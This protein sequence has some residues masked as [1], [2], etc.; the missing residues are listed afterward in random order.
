MTF[1]INRHPGTVIFVDDD[2]NFLKTIRTVVDQD[3]SVRTFAMTSDFVDHIGAKIAVARD[4][5]TYQRRAMDRYRSG[6]SVATEVLRYWNSFPERFALPQ[7]VVIDY[8]MPNMTGLEALE[9]CE[10]WNGKR[11]LMTGLADEDLVCKAFN[12]KQIDYYISKKN[13]KLISQITKAVSLMMHRA[14]DCHIPQWNAWFAS[15]QSQH[16]L[17]LANEAVNSELNAILGSDFEHVTIGDPFGV[18]GLGHSGG[19]KWIQLE[20]AATLDTAATMAAEAGVAESDVR[21][22][23]EGRALSD[24]RIQ[25]SLSAPAEQTTIKDVAFTVRIPGTSE[26]VYGAEFEVVTHAAP[27]KE[28]CY[29]AWLG[30]QFEN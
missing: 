2:A 20:T 14:F 11:I 29:F 18:M 4:L 27:P 8:Y 5:E 24:I 16:H 9:K 13:S 15:L 28:M 6:G 10:G 7:V 30:R 26:V 22:I 3:W 17:I 1:P 21:R 19:V 25:K 23:R 12:D